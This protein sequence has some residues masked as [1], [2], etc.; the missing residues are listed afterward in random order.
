MLIH[1]GDMTPVGTLGQLEAVAAFLGRQPH[2]E[3]IVIAGNHDWCFARPAD[4]PLA[5]ACIERVA[6]YLFDRAVT[7]DCGLKVYGSPWQPWFLDWAFNLRHRAGFAAVWAK[8][9]S[10]TD[11]LITHGPPA[12]IAD[13]CTN[14]RHAGCSELR[15]R[16]EVIKPRVHVFGHIHEAHGVV[17]G[18][19]TVFVNAACDAYGVV[20]PDQP[21]GPI[22]LD[23]DLRTRGVELRQGRRR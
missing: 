5:R 3:K 14:G 10:D 7:L 9:P 18:D 20:P 22:V 15:A 21:G 19:H 16:I 4:E 23:I 11:I 13:L 2:A 8:I 12:N 17:E 6:T 1:A